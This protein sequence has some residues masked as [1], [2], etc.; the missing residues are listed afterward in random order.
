MWSTMHQCGQGDIGAT[1]GHENRRSLR[2]EGNRGKHPCRQTSS[3]KTWNHTQK[4]QHSDSNGRHTDPQNHGDRFM[5]C[6]LVVALGN[7]HQS[8]HQVSLFFLPVWRPGGAGVWKLSSENRWMFACEMQR[9]DFLHGISPSRDP[10][11]RFQP[12]I[13]FWD[14]TWWNHIKHY[15]I[16]WRYVSKSGTLPK[17]HLVKI[18]EIYAAPNLEN[19]TWLEGK[20][21]RQISPKGL[22]FLILLFYGYLMDIVWYCWYDIVW[23]CT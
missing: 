16:V 8:T 7:R 22:I 10:F 4:S 11:F 12:L 14:C 6:L 2:V 18:V 15:G 20:D 23:Y 13:I 21:I 9:A 1:T 3:G 5:M 19:F 17:I